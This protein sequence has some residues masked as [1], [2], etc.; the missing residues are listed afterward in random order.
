MSNKLRD[1]VEE[2]QYKH[3]MTVAQVA[4]SIDYSRVHLTKEMAKDSSPL[5][6]LLIAKYG[7][8]LQNVSRETEDDKSISEKSIHN[9]TESA[10]MLAE[11]NLILAKNSK[12][13]TD[14]IKSTAS[15]ESKNPSILETRLADLQEWLIEVAAGRR[16][17]SIPEA[18]AAFRTKVFGAQKKKKA[19]GTRDGSGK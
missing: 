18:D 10:R 11:S 16:Y 13:L 3:K 5:T 2:I 15:D 8:T 14:L 9:L 17:K 1:L 4:K 12:E 19:E 6:E 7:E